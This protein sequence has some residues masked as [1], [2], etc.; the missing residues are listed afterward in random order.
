MSSA[1]RTL[2][3][4]M[5]TVPEVIKEVIENHMDENVFISIPAV[6]TRTDNYTTKQV[7]DVK[8]LIGTVYPDGDVLNP[9]Q[10]KSVF[11]KLQSGGGF[12]IKLP[13]SVGDKVTLH[14]THK[15]LNGFLANDG[16]QTNEELL[17]NFQLKDCYVTHGFGTR[18]VNQSPSRTDMI[19]EAPKSITTIKPSGDIITSCTSITTT[20]TGD[21]TINCSNANINASSKTTVTTPLA[22]FSQN[23]KINGT[24]EVVGAATSAVSFSAPSFAGSGGGGTMTIG[25]ITVSGDATIGGIAY[26]GHT[27]EDA[28]GRPTSTPQ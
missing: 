16:R 11:V 28:E 14:W 7:V 1:D 12:T 21:V 22:E 15:S 27:H 17:A 18:L 2:G 26:L 25:D 5:K 10:I 19:I 13:I 6:V 23:V 3:Y 8:P 4:G 20:A 9:P 24:L